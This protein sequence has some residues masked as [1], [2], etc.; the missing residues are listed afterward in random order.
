LKENAQPGRISGLKPPLFSRPVIR[1]KTTNMPKKHRHIVSI[2]QMTENG[3]FVY[4]GCES[5]RGEAEFTST[6]NQCHFNGKILT[7]IKGGERGGN[8]RGM[9]DGEVYR[10][11]KFE[12][13]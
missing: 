1:K 11:M 12:K 3:A 8:Y 5:Y 2:T 7:K 9:E 6:Y 13:L 10:V 4:G